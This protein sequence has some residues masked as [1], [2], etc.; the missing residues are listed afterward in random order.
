MEKPKMK[1]VIKRMRR[2]LAA[3]LAI[4]HQDPDRGA[5]VSGAGVSGAGVSAAGLVG[6]PPP[7]LVRKLLVLVL[8]LHQ[9]QHQH[10]LMVT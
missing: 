2:E 1:A 4:G 6:R 10:Q 5:G 7:A 9:H 3:I 8:V